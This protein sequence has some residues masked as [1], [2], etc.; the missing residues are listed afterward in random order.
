MA[1]ATVSAGA[2]DAS[3][4]VEG[5]EYSRKLNRNCALPDDPPLGTL[6]GMEDEISVIVRMCVE[7]ARCGHAEDET[8]K[9]DVPVDQAQPMEA[10][11]P[12]KCPGCGAPILMHVKRWQEL[13]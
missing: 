8:Y 12:G 5:T 6:T 10:D 13:Q 2:N 9:F 3:R 7:C 11:E 4:C 1:A